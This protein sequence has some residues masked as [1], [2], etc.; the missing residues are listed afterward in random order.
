MQALIVSTF[1]SEWL[2]ICCASILIQQITT[3]M[4]ASNYSLIKD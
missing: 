3:V 1:G 4:R 2:F